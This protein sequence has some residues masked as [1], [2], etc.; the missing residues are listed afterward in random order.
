M[1]TLTL[2][3]ALLGPDSLTRTSY[4]VV[5][6]TP[7]RA[8]SMRMVVNRLDADHIAIRCRKSPSGTLFSYWAT[9]GRN[10]LMFPRADTAFEG[11]AEEA[12]R[13]FPDGPELFREQWMALLEGNPPDQMLGF[14]YAVDE[15]GWQVVRARDSA[16]AIRWRERQRRTDSRYAEGLFEPSFPAHYTIAALS[17]MVLSWNTDA[18]D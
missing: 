11:H 7:E 16:V 15:A 5:L 4:D 1:I 6:E 12:F 10:V 2:L 9:P 13:L 14:S 18:L 17:E 8:L 3:L